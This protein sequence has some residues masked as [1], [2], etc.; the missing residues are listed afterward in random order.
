MLQIKNTLGG[1]GATKVLNGVLEQYYASNSTIDA[2]TFVN[3]INNPVVKSGSMENSSDFDSGT[4]PV[5]WAT[6]LSDTKVAVL[7]EGK[8]NYYFYLYIVDFSGDT[9][10]FG[11]PVLVHNSSVESYFLGIETID[12]STCCIIINRSNKSGSMLAILCGVSDTTVTVKSTITVVS[13][14]YYLYSNG[15]TTKFSDGKIAVFFHCKSSS[16]SVTGTT[17]YCYTILTCT[18]DSVTAITPVRLTY[19][20]RY[21]KWFQLSS[22]RVGLLYTNSTDTSYA[23]IALHEYSN[24]SIGSLI[25]NNTTLLSTN[26]T[27]MPMS[28]SIAVLD[29]TRILFGF[30]AGSD[31]VSGR[32]VI[33]TCTDSDITVGTALALTESVADYFHALLLDNNKVVLR[34]NKSSGSNITYYKLVTCNGSTITI[35][36]ESS[37]NPSYN[38]G[39]LLKIDSERA[40]SVTKSGSYIIWIRIIR[41]GRYIA[42]AVDTIDGLLISKATETKKGKTYILAK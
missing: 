41:F 32:Y 13:G 37:I 39:P 15:S 17:Y 30:K 35:Q 16:N 26:S 27:I 22:S 18:T 28:D 10:T 2:N 3:L 8:S 14:T 38:S 21:A 6:K 42:R 12:N 11:T 25:H 19:N 4:G 9:I 1:G 36:T 40:V 34:F 29:S 33:C 23:G 31:S 7:H 20:P 5:Q 24:G